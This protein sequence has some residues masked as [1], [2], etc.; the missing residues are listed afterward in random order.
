MTT[1]LVPFTALLDVHRNC[2]Q[3]QETSQT[4]R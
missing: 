4:I 2:R 1:L 3:W